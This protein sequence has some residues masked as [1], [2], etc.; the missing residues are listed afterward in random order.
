MLKDVSTIVR[1]IWKRNKNDNQCTEIVI[2]AKKIRCLKIFPTHKPTQTKFS[3][4]DY[5][6][7]SYKINKKW[8]FSQW[9]IT[10][11]IWL[12]EPLTSRNCH[13]ISF[14]LDT[15]IEVEPGEPRKIRNPS[16][17]DKERSIQQQFYLTRSILVKAYLRRLTLGLLYIIKTSKDMMSVPFMTLVHVNFPCIS[18]L[19]HSIWVRKRW[20][21]SSFEFTIWPLI[22]MTSFYHSELFK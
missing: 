11:S 8:H 14:I 2:K 16:T 20:T 4:L 17:L 18:C 21:Q 13:E 12:M 7:I 1:K 19:K 22:L 6:F 3:I 15:I 10:S 9:Q 5:Y